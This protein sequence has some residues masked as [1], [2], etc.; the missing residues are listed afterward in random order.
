MIRTLL[1]ACWLC[2]AVHCA[3]AAEP[4]LPAVL[5]APRSVTQLDGGFTLD[6]A[7]VVCPEQGL[8]PLADYLS[9]YLGLASDAARAGEGALVLRTEPRLG[10]EAYELR[11][12]PGRIEIAG[13]DR[14]GVFCGIQTL[15]QLLPPEVYARRCPLP[16]RLACR[17]VKDAP[18]YAYRG[19][20]LDVARTWIGPEPLRRYID[21]MAY[22]KINKLH[23]HLA[24]DEGWRIEILSHPELTEIG[25]FR[26][27]DSPVRPVYGKW[28]E[29]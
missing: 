14:G 7:T 11:I 24:D 19:M 17:E 5:P 26:G 3:A 15:F 28:D 13:G 27:G 29:K 9:D 21:L 1:S 23:L 8:E 18:R 20:M 12:L 4:P 16:V 10:A 25:G 2:C 6:A 22:H